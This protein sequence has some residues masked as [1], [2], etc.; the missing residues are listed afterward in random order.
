MQ[1]EPGEE[2]FSI[3]VKQGDCLLVADPK[4]LTPANRRQHKAC[5][6]LVHEAEMAREAARL[7]ALK[8]AEAEAADKAVAYVRVATVVLVA[9]VCIGSL[10]AWRRR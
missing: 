1:L 2:L 4:F 6:R 7:A 3:E 5:E 9:I 8:A 10:A